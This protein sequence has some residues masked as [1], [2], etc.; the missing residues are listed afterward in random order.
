AGVGVDF[1]RFDEL[2]HDGPILAVDEAETEGPASGDQ[3]VGHRRAL[4]R[5]P[6]QL[7]IEAELRGP[8]EGHQIA[9]DAESASDDVQ[10]ARHGPEDPPSQ[11]VVLHRV[12]TL[13]EGSDRFTRRSGH[14]A[15]ARWA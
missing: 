11:L 2:A 3:L 15:D 9:L 1:D 12:G 6:D 5:Y 7:G 8:V 10:S 13:R 14:R 4:D